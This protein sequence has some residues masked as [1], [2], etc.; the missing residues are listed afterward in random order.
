MFTRNKPNE[1]MKR[2]RNQIGR[3]IPLSAL[4]TIFHNLK[5]STKINFH[6]KKF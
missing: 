2:S 5:I 6:K 3:K 4:K 1:L